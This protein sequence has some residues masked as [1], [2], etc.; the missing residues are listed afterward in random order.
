MKTTFAPKFF[1]DVGTDPDKW[2]AA[3]R[4]RLGTDAPDDS[5][6]RDFFEAA[7]LDAERR[8]MERAAKVADEY[9]WDKHALAQATDIGRAVHYQAAEIAAAIRAAK[10]PQ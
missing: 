3:L 8:G 6:L 2:V 9:V 5:V 10:A 7:L 1:K 4:V